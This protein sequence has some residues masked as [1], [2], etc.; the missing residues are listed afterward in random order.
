MK[1]KVLVRVERDAALEA[2]RTLDALSIALLAH[3]HRWP[4]RL[5]RQYERVRTRLVSAAGLLAQLNELG[6]QAV[7]D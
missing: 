6:D 3:E 2:I 1:A 4:K 5:K 7:F